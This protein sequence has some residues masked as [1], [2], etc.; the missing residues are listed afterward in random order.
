MEGASLPLC[1]DGTKEDDPHMSEFNSPFDVFDVDENLETKGIRVDYGPFWFQVGRMDKGGTPFARFMT[2]KLRP[3]TRAI[4]LGEMDN[5]VAEALTREGFSKHLVYAWGSKQHGDGKM[6]G[7]D[8][9]A[10]PFTPE[11]VEQLFADLPALFE[12]LLNESK[13]MVNFRKARTEIDA[14]N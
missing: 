2:E 12:D 6:V 5:K 10:I 13:K 7:R 11:N 9:K 1:G 8:G 3:Y 14:K 4:Q